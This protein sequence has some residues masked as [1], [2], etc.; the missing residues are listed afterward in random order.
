MILVSKAVLA[1]LMAATGG[2]KIQSNVEGQAG[3]QNPNSFNPQISLVSDFR[4][5]LSDNNPSDEKKTQLKEVELGIAADVDPFLKEEAYIG[6]GFEDGE[7]I[8][9]VEEAFGRYTNL[10]RGMSAKFGKIAAAIGRVQRNH[11]DSLN[12]LDYP[13]VIQDFFGDNRVRAGFI[14]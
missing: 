6:F 12:F 9:E 10:G 1:A 4:A 13:L 2:A 8:A 14:E 7:A 3:P 5:R 11:A